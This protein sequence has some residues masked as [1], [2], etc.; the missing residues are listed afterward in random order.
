MID[1]QQRVSCIIPAKNESLSLKS[2]LPLVRSYLPAGSEIIVVNDGSTDDT[3]A[4]CAGSAVREVRNPYSKGNGAAI[5]SG[6]RAASGDILLF[7]DAD[8]Q[9][10]PEDIPRLLAGLDEHYDMVVGARTFVSQASVFRGI[11]NSFYNRFA[12]MVVGHRIE[13]LTSGFRAVKARLF[14]KFL[15]LLP[16]GFSYPTTITMGFFR[17]GYSVRYVPITAEA[18]TG[19]SHIRPVQDGLRFLLTI[20]KVG[21]LYSPLKIFVPA[22]LLCIA[23]GLLNYL[24][25]YLSEMRLTN[26][27]VILLISG[28]FLFLIGLVAEQIT[29]LM[30]KDMD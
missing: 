25:T 14:R 5:K 8:G 13:D 3:S 28:V 29:A 16:N 9:H 26:M 12:S 21:T 19:E 1:A 27:T 11:A 23:G 10:N 24:L 6:A 20:F 30:H 22:A 18:R 7:M 15:Y 2:L 4:V 17:A